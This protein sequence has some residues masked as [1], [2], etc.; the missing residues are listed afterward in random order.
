MSRQLQIGDLCITV[1]T[2]H[3]ACNEGALVTITTIDNSQKGWDGESTPYLIRRIDGQPH[4]S[5]TD[6]K[7]GAQRW[8]K[9]REAWCAGYKLRRIELGICGKIKQ[10][11]LQVTV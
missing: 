9:C 7:T 5:T 1:N 8:C 11:E 3:P 4:I 6:M 10:V 2:K